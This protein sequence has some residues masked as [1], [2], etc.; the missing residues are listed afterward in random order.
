MVSDH[1]AFTRADVSKARRLLG[2]HATYDLRLG[3]AQT[4]DWYM[5]HLLPAEQR[6]LV[7]A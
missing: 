2:Y 4:I 1:V 7:H 3:L 6:R 5:A